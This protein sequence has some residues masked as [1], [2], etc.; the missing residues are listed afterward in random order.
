MRYGTYRYR[1]FSEIFTEAG[2]FLD[3]WTESNYPKIIPEADNEYGADMT[4]I[5]YMLLAT[6]A[7]S[8]IA[9]LDETQFVNQLFL[10]IFQYGPTWA[11]RLE[12]QNKLRALTDEEL[13]R[14]GKAFY[15]HAMNPSTAPVNDSTEALPKIDSQNVTS[16]I[17]NTMEGYDNLM[18]LLDD[19][20][21]TD[22]LDKFKPLFNSWVMPDAPV[23]YCE[24]D[25]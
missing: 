10:T 7:N 15:N 11:K 3:L 1:T 23:C 21:T 6:Y 5:Y 20:I 13:V 2:V 17:R 18:G 19:S 8:P 14:G 4:T 24:E 9:S 25:E 12:L 22:F 16:Y